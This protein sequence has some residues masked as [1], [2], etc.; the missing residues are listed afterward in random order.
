MALSS[1][2]TIPCRTN[3]V[4]LRSH[5]HYRETHTTPCF[6]QGDEEEVTESW[7]GVGMSEAAFERLRERRYLAAVR[8]IWQT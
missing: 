8:R 6:P 4:T 1:E 3:G 2:D 7:S 5:V